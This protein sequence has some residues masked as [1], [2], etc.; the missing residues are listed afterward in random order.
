[1]YVAYPLFREKAQSSG[2]SLMLIRDDIAAI[3]PESSILVLMFIGRM[4][5]L[6]VGILML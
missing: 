4:A 6:F 2:Q 5:S 1:M 3:A